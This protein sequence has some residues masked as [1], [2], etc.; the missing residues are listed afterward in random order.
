MSYIRAEEVLPQELIQAIQ[1]YVS[2]K[3][4]YIP[5]IEKQVWGSRTQTK[6]YYRS[7]DREICAKH[8]RGVPV[9]AL[10]EEYCLSVKSIRRILRAAR[11]EA[12]G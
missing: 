5:C 6:Q 3:S 8:G 1:Q 7:R 4:I 2:G 9:E 11:Q 12:D 10:A